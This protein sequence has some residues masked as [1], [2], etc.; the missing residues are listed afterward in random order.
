M[1]A[2]PD[3]NCPHGSNHLSKGTLGYGMVVISQTTLLA[4][5]RAV[6][7]DL[8]SGNY[9][10]SDAH[11]TSLLDVALRSVNTAIGQDYTIS[12]VEEDGANALIFFAAYLASVG[13]GAQKA[14]TAFR[15]SLQSFRMIDKSVLVKNFRTVAE[16]YL[17]AYQHAIISDAPGML[18]LTIGEDSY[19][20]SVEDDQYI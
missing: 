8:D 4:Q 5:L 7:L 12:T 6:L 20:S 2:V 18:I 15:Y 1:E 14:K 3:G 16:L 9:E 13:K 11:L 10:F 17:E 19:D